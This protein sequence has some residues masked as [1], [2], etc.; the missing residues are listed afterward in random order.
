AS[1]FFALEPVYGILIAWWLFAEQPTVRMLLGGA[2]II[3]A[4]LMV[5]RA[6]KPA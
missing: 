4:V 3:S 1:L 2:L 6:P 5:Q